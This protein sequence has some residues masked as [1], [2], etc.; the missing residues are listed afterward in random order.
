MIEFAKR[1]LI[2]LI[3]VFVFSTLL[4]YGYSMMR[5]E[6]IDPSVGTGIAL[7][8]MVIFLIGLNWRKRVSFLP[9]GRASTWLQIHIYVGLF[10]VVVF[11]VHTGLR[12]PNG[13]FEGIIAALFLI[14]A[15][16]GVF[17]LILS[18]V[19]PRRLTQNGGNV[20]YENIPYQ[21]RLLKNKAEELVLKSIEE[22]KKS[23]LADFYVERIEVF[24]M[25]SRRFFINHIFGSK[26]HINPLTTRMRAMHRYLNER[27]IEIM[28]ELE[29]L[30]VEYDQL[31][32]QQSMLAILKCWLFS[33][34]PLS[35]SLLVFGFA[36]GF[37]A[38]RFLGG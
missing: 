11:F 36:H 26:K 35:Y 18:R 4:L 24:L 6:L 9:V 37:I 21:K 29:E 5:A 27:E 10:S 7:L 8:L 32:Y 19:I 30:L 3:F 1:R 12:I 23:T 31:D 22:T 16:S 15:F 20:A 25:G 2:G 38:Y 34:I 17:G 14:V 33:H 13:T 28:N